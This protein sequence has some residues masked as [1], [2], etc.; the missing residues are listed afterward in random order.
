MAFVAQ[1]GLADNI[2]LIYLILKCDSVKPKAAQKGGRW[3]VRI[4][5][6]NRLAAS[7]AVSC[8]IGES[9]LSREIGC[10]DRLK[11]SRGRKVV[12]TGGSRGICYHPLL[13]QARG[14]AHLSVHPIWGKAVF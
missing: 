12:K 3:P 1:N 8:E 4:P 5:G 14:S 2:E 13:P 9:P 11:R 10:N 6:A 7:I